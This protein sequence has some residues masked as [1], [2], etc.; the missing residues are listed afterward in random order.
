MKTRILGFTLICLSA[1][2]YLAQN[3]GINTDGSMPTMMLDVK[4]NPASAS[5]GIQINNPN[6]GNGD[7]ILNFQN[8]G[9][10]TWT[11]GFDD[12]DSDKFKFSSASGSVSTNTLVT[13]QQNG[14]VGIGTTTPTAPLEIRSSTVPQF[15]ITDGGTGVNR[16]AVITGNNAD[17]GELW[18]FG[19]SSSGNQDVII[20]NRKSA[21]LILGTNNSSNDIVIEPNGYVGINNTAAANMLDVYEN[22]TATGFVARIRNGGTGTSGV[23]GADVL[24]LHIGT[25]ASLTS[26]NVFVGFFDGNSSVGAIR[27]NGSNTVT[28]LTTSDQRL[29]ENIVPTKTSLTN[30]MRLNVV[31]YNMIGD[32]ASQVKT[33]FIAQEL[34]KVYPDIVAKGGDNVDTDPWMVSYSGLTP[35]LTKAIQELKTIVDDQQKEIEELKQ[36]ILELQSN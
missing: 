2:I 29:K 24:E 16:N 25:T 11:I 13:I 1:Q 6:T 27:G 4:T 5:D 23:N 9:T 22:R 31:D 14:R 28:Y 26:N 35:M 19:S 10:N 7:A 32:S 34:H 18:Y 3:V 33:G 17:A 21:Q 20:L 15:E 36:L 12:S 30:I 8:N